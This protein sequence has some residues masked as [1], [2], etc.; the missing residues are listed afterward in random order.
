MAGKTSGEFFKSRKGRQKSF[1]P[2]GTFA[3]GRAKPRA[4]ALGYFQG[5]ARAVGKAV[6]GHRSPR[7]WREFENIR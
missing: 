1:V 2:D 7:R 4:K 5:K 3:I 6:E